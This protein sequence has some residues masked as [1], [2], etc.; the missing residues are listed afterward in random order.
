MSVNTG[1]INDGHY[2]TPENMRKGVPKKTP[3]AERLLGPFKSKGKSEP[4]LTTGEMLHNKG[5]WGKKK[6]T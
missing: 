5:K 6:V 2:L 3:V 4:S 1:P